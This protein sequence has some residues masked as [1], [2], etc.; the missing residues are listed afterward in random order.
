SLVTSRLEITGVCPLT[1]RWIVKLGTGQYRPV[2]VKTAGNEHFE[3][4]V[5]CNGSCGGKVAT[6]VQ[7]CR[8]RNC[9]RLRIINLDAAQGAIGPDSS[10][11][12]DFSASVRE[13]NSL[14]VISRVSQHSLRCC[15]LARRGIVQFG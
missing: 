13:Q 12:Q 5:S 9:I 15:E 8:R 2:A 11:D 10:D 6:G 3:G 4:S 7:R 1:G 14:V